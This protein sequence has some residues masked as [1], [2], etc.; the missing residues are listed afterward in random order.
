MYYL[1]DNYL[2]ALAYTMTMVMTFRLTLMITIS[3]FS[4]CSKMP[5][6]T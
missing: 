2:T 1:P 6:K 4:V 5:A 3:M